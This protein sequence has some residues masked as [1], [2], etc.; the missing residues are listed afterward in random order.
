MT[1][2][3][4]IR[5][6]MQITIKN[7][8]ALNPVLSFEEASLPKYIINTL[9]DFEK[10]TPIQSQALPIILSGQDMVGIAATGSG[11]TLAYLIPGI[12]HVND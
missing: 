8:T 11:K 7:G 5:A 1:D 9:H 4:G 2:A 6:K 12:I 3:E 10:P